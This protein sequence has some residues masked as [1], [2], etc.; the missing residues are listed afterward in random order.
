MEPKPLSESKTFWINLAAIAV[1]F[2]TY[3]AGQ[4]WVKAYPWLVAAIPIF[5]GALNIWLRTQT[6]APIGPKPETPPETKPVETKPAEPEK[7]LAKILKKGKEWIVE[8]LADG[9]LTL[10]DLNKPLSEIL[11]LLAEKEAARAG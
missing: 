4:E 3:L 11:Q 9:Q 8:A 5:L 2:F 6:D 10:S 1:S 7:P